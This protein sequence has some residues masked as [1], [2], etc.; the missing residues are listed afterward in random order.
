MKPSQDALTHP[1]LFFLSTSKAVMIVTIVISALLSLFIPS[2]LASFVAAIVS[3]ILIARVQDR[4]LR[5]LDVHPAWI[6]YLL[7]SLGLSLAIAV[8][9]QVASLLT[10][11]LFGWF[12]DAMG[13]AIFWLMQYRLF[14]RFIL[15]PR[16]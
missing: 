10:L 11:L 6:R 13:T 3:G 15:R 14:K 8:L 16:P 1:F 5:E 4:L 2:G 9:V 12:W 7:A